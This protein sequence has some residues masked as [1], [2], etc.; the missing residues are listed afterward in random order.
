MLVRC[1]LLLSLPL[2]LVACATVPPP[3][4]VPDA[5]VGYEA[6]ADKGAPHYAETDATAIM[7][8]LQKPANPVPLYPP[9]RLES[10]AP[11]VIVH[12][13]LIVAD[14]GHVSEVRIDGADAGGAM[15]DFANAVAMATLAWRFE[16]L[17][18]TRWQARPDGS[19][20]RVADEPMPFSQDYVF[21]FAVVDGKPEVGAAK[22]DHGMP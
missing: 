19:E 10:G 8:P 18:I 6:V 5:R 15:A 16:P 9:N 3:L 1:G 7:S 17:R 4:P 22:P 13:L 11:E 14:D 20:V 21:R 2:A 12:A